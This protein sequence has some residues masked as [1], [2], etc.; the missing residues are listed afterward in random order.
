MDAWTSSFRIGGTNYSSGGA[1]GRLILGSD[2]QLH[3][4]GIGTTPTNSVTVGYNEGAGGTATG[5]LEA[6]QGSADLHM[7]ELNVGYNKASTGSASGTLRWNQ[8]NAIDAHYVYFGR[9]PDATG[10]LEVPAGGTLRLGT[11]ADPIFGL[12]AAW[13]TGTGTA[14]A[15]LDFSTTDPTFEMH[16]DAG[17]VVGLNHGTG[18]ANGKLVLGDNS[19]VYAGTPTTPGNPGIT[20]GS[21]GGLNGAAV[22]VFDGSRGTAE[23][24]VNELLVGDNK[25]GDPAALGTAS[26]TFTTG[27]HTTLTATT[28][29]IARGPGTP[30]ATVNMN[31]GLFAAD[32]SLRTDRRLRSTSRAAGWP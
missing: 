4:E 23:L 31:G 25:S 12:Y 29:Q 28:V 24:H 8:S 30:P 2:S 32:T 22:G 19:H 21:N 13:N 26:G 11:A 5:L 1:D 18:T 3:I 9:G 16:A 14:S 6:L 7:N 15:N 20:V 27:E 10:T 17:F